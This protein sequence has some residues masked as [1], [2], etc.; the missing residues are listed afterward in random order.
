MA[1]KNYPLRFLAMN[2]MILL[3]HKLVGL[4]E[5]SLRTSLLDLLLRFLARAL[6]L[7]WLRLRLR[8]LLVVLVNSRSQLERRGKRA[9]TS[10]LYRSM[11]QLVSLVLVLLCLN[12]FHWH[13]FLM[14]ALLLLF[15]KGFQVSVS[16]W[17][18][19]YLLQQ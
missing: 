14:L 2:S 3:V 18:Q 7:H 6:N 10:L 1:V 13:V 8:L 4:L 5:H 16:C 15:L 9:K 19:Q 12:V 11:D 17:I